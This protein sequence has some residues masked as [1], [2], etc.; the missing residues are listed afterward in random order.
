MENTAQM[1]SEKFLQPSADPY[2]RAL[3]LRSIE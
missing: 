3:R 2:T 1:V